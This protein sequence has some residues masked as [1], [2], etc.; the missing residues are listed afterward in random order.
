MPK[1]RIHYVVWMNSQLSIARH[2]GGVK[3]NGIDYILDKE[4]CKECISALK[5]MGE[6]KEVEGKY[7]PDLI[8]I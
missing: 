8:E 7:F 6:Y 1:K 2:Y 4:S 3:Y 5:E